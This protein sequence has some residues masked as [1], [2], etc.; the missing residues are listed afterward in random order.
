LKGKAD[1]KE[2]VN[3][4]RAKMRALSRCHVVVS[5]LLSLSVIL[6]AVGCGTSFM[7][8]YQSALLSTNDTRSNMVEWK[9]D[10]MSSNYQ[11]ADKEEWDDDRQ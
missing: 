3:E 4:M 1:Q 10:L 6:S 7:G 5:M 9:F 8:R 2:E 11:K